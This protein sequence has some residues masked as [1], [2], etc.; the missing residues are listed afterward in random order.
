MSQI[1]T[2][3][4]QDLGHLG[5]VAG[6]C[7]ELKIAETIDRLLPPTAKQVSHGT[8][9]CAMILN[10]LGFVNQRLYLV[11][12]FFRNKPVEHLLGADI[13]ADQ[14][15]DDTLGR[16]LDA[17]F[18]SNPTEVYASVAATSCTILA[19]APRFAHLDST[20]FHVDGHYNADRPAEEGGIRLTK[21]YSR[22]H[23]P[24]LNQCILNLIVESQASI[25]IHMSAASGNTE[26]KTGFRTLL[27]T[28]VEHLQNVHEFTYVVAD[29][30]LYVEKTLSTLADQMLFISRMP[31]TLDI[32]KDMLS[33]VE[34]PLMHRI[35]KNYAYQEVG[36]VYGGVKQR[37]IIVFSQ[38]A[39]ERDLHTL[40]RRMITGGERERKAFEKLCRRSFACREDAQRAWEKF[41]PTLTYLCVPTLDIQEHAHYARRGKPK[42]G[43]QPERIDYRLTGA[44]ASC[45]QTRKALMDQ[46]GLFVL[47]TNELDANQLSAPEVLTGYKG[48]AHAEKGFRFLKHPEFLASALFLQKPERIM[49]LLMI[50]TLCLMVYAALEYRIRQGLQHQGKTVLNQ[51]GKPT[52]TPTARWIFHCFVGI[53]VLFQGGQRMGIVNLEAQHWEIINVLGYHSYYT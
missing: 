53:H 46:Q 40:D 19:L 27:S 8:A 37:W 47:A 6:M 3:T 43:E 22:D 39:Y 45:L 14:L 10:G 48:Q 12:D 30:A 38:A 23:R 5:L 26:D 16:T 50:M 28:H 33:K 2:Y 25:P 17:I 32:V 31:G 9:V 15:N 35:D 29:S 4:T 34:V 11:P 42:H 7:H 18:A 13:T 44:L 1:F 41:H 24:E 36:G 49:A 21:G 20:S 52:V 51:V